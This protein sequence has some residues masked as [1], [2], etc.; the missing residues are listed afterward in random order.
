[1]RERSRCPLAWGRGLGGLSVHEKKICGSGLWRMHTCLSL[2]TSANCAERSTLPWPASLKSLCKVT[3]QFYP[4]AAYVFSIVP[5]LFAWKGIQKGRPESAKGNRRCNFFVWS[6]DHIALASC[7]PIELEGNGKCHCSTND[8]VWSLDS[9]STKGVETQEGLR[10]MGNG[11][12]QPPQNLGDII[13]ISWAKT[14][15]RMMTGRA[16]WIVF[17]T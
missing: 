6:P 9:N 5:H 16:L 7:V 12:P 17:S 11:H 14:R 3:R 15:E 2:T 10:T 1:M 13:Q 8:L 4:S